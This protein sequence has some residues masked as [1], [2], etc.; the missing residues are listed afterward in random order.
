M[1]R[2]PLPAGDHDVTVDFLNG[3]G[4]VARS[5]TLAGVKITAGRRTYAMVR[6]AE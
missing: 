1:A 4:G 3:S 2:L 6:S 5:R